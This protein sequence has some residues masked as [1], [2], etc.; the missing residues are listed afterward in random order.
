MAGESSKG[1]W[2]PSKHGRLGKPMEE[3]DTEDAPKFVSTQDDIA[4]ELLGFKK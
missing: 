1:T 2:D 3:K 4:A